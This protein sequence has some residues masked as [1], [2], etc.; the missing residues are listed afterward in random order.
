M[1]AW[2]DEGTWGGGEYDT[3]KGIRVVG[4]ALVTGDVAIDIDGCTTELTLLPEG[5]EVGVATPT[6]EVLIPIPE[7]ED[8]ESDVDICR[9]ER[10]GVIMAGCRSF[11]DW[12]DARVMLT[13]PASS[14]MYVKF[15]G[16]RDLTTT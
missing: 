11:S 15:V 13:V 4:A 10:V 5:L 3:G 8:V 6:V 16:V 7:E 1:V 12:L 2:E 9:T 14:E